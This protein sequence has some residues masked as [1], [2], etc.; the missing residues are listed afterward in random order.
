MLSGNE[1]L[2]EIKKYIHLKKKKK[3]SGAEDK[4]RRKERI[5]SER[6]LPFLTMLLPRYSRNK[7]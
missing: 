2:E 4:Q 1:I 7:K 5:K 6:H 3:T